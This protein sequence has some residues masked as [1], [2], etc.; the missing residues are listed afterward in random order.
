MESADSARAAL[1]GRMRDAGDL[2]IGLRSLEDIF[3][4]KVALMG[5]VWGCWARA[6]NN[7]RLANSS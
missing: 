3:G 1:R 7:S 2:S 4:G 6:G 5:A